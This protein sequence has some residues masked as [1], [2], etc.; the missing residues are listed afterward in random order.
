MTS[1]R[2]RENLIQELRLQGI[3]DERVLEVMTK[4]E[5][6]QFVEEALK[7]EAYKNRALP[8][9]HAQTISQP[10][11]VALMT[12]AVMGGATPTKRVLEVGTGSGYQTAVLAALVETVFTVERIRALTESARLR[13]ASLNIRNV[14]FGYAD[15]TLGWP[16]YAPYDGIVVTAGGTEIPQALIDQLAPGGRLVIPVGP[17]GAQSLRLIERTMRGTTVEQDLGGVTFVPLLTGKV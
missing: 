11:I 6:H 13:L 1:S 16:P 15:G 5:R 8:I 14:H 7:S 3:H 10:Y 4:I 12:Q 17:T 2:V 9:G